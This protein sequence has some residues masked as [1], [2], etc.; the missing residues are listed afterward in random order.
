MHF[1]EHQFARESESARR[2]GEEKKE[3]SDAWHFGVWLHVGDVPPQLSKGSGRR[4][5]R[6]R[7]GRAE[8]GE[9]KEKVEARKRARKGGGAVS[10]A[11]HDDAITLSLPPAPSF[12]ALVRLHH[13]YLV[14]CTF[15]VEES[16]RATSKEAEGDGEYW[17]NRH[18]FLVNFPARATEAR[19]KGGRARSYTM[20]REW[21]MLLRGGRGMTGAARGAATC[22]EMAERER[23]GGHIPALISLA[24]LR[25]SLTRLL[26]SRP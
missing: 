25:P 16:R 13:P 23:G 3:S 8:E 12:S 21:G 10:E 9:E 1:G 6:R 24:P 7:V 18:F 4:P 26:A 15:L 5:Q 19:G 2:G 17:P 11:L 20:K 22:R 14:G